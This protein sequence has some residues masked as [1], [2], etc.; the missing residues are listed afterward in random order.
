MNL[1]IITFQRKF[2]SIVWIHMSR[3]IPRSH[4][5]TNQWRILYNSNFQK[6]GVGVSSSNKSKCQQPKKT[7]GQ[8]TQISQVQ[9]CKKTG[10][11]SHPATNLNIKSHWGSNHPNITS[12]N[13]QKN[14]EGLSSSNKLGK[15]IYYFGRII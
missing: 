3:G 1:L 6:N 15:K 13:L 4:P 7:G 9:I 8:F 10:W 12:S 14:G 11:G 2:M 5:A